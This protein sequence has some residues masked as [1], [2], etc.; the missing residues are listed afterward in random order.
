MAEDNEATKKLESNIWKYQLFHLLRGALFFTPIITLFFMDHG[1]SMKEVM[2]IESMFALTVVLLEVPTGYFADK[3]GRKASMAVG[4]I[5]IFIAA[6]ILLMSEGF[7]GFLIADIIWG[8]GNSFCSGSDTALVYDTLLSL[9]RKKEYK[10]LEGHARFIG[11]SS[12]AT[13]GIIGGFVAAAE[14]RIA[15][16]LGALSFFIMIFVVL[17]M[18]E[19]KMRKRTYESGHIVQLYKV[20]RFAI[21]RNKTLKWMILYSAMISGFGIISFWLSQPYFRQIGVPIVYFGI[22]FAAFTFLRGLG[23]KMAHRYERLLGLRL[24]VVSLPIIMA[25]SFFVLGMGFWKSFAL[26]SISAYFA[27]EFFEGLEFPIISDLMNRIVWSENRATIIS[28]NNLMS[29]LMFAVF[30]PLFGISADKYGFR[31]TFCLCGAMMLLMGG[32]IILMMR[33]HKAV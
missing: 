1:L 5:T 12:E 2:F 16:A 4:S 17:S 6:L 25:S 20:V 10:R 31:T 7:Y 15:I 13:S 14:P 33:R 28:V 22:I 26:I 27:L 21:H 8:V 3:I 9:K 19:P 30:A 18:H 32:I 24:A 23:Y 11:T 29:R